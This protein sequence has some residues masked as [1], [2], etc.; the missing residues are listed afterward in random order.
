MEGANSI[1][2][3]SGSLAFFDSEHCSVRCG[4]E[5]GLELRNWGGCHA[6]SGFVSLRAGVSPESSV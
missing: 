6:V 2:T 4:D 3:Q 5:Y 1:S